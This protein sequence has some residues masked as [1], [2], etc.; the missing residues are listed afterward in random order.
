MKRIPT[1]VLLGPFL[2][3]LICLAFA[4]AL[5]YPKPIFEDARYWPASFMVCYAFSAL[6]MLLTAW[7]DRRLS[8]KPWRSLVCGLA[9]FGIAFA[10]YY[11]LM[12][13]GGREEDAKIF[14]KYWFYVGLVWGLPAVVCSWLVGMMKS[15]A[16]KAA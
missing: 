15:K 6:P 5:M 14:Q 11:G 3:W 13:E 1:F 8:E 2:S 9:G 16:S 10:L 12:H 7:I 4:A